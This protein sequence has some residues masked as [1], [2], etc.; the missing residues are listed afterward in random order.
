MLKDYTWE[1]LK[2]ACES[3][4]IDYSQAAEKMESWDAKKWAL[5]EYAGEDITL[6]DEI[7]EL[8]IDTDEI[9]FNGEN[10]LVL[11]EDEADERWDEELDLYIDDCLEIPS[12]IRPYFD[13]EAWKRDARFDG[14]GYA[15]SR[16]DGYENQY[17]IDFDDDSQVWINIYRM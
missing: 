1:N 7:N 6:I 3:E 10:L 12:H 2:T 8:D 11:D 4:E 13:E 9:S 17:R 16:Y 14:R 5:F 15:I